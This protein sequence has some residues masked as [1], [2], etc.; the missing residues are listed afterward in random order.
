MQKACV[1]NVIVLMAEKLVPLRV[2]IQ[3]ECATP[4]VSATIATAIGTTSSTETK[5]CSSR[6]MS[7]K[8]E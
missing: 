3:T 7:K 5:E 4:E 2:S 6:K 1:K 8:F